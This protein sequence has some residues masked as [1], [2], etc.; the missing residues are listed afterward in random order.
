M[1]LFDFFNRKISNYQMCLPLYQ[2]VNYNCRID[3]SQLL[4]RIKQKKVLEK[5]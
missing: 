4:K 2:L 1:G 5:C 3:Y